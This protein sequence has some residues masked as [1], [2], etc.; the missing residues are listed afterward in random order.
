VGFVADILGF[1]NAAGPHFKLDYSTATGAG[2]TTLTQAQLAS[3]TGVSNILYASADGQSVVLR[4]DVD[5]DTIATDGYP[6]S[7][8]REEASNGTS[9]RAFTDTTGSHKIE[10]LHLPMHLPP[11]NP[12][13]VLLQ[14]HD[15]AQDLI[16]IVVKARSDYATT[17][18]LEVAL[19]LALG[20]SSTSVGI[21]RFIADFGTLAELSSNPKWLQSSITTGLIGPGSTAGWSCTV[22]G[23]T[24]NSWDVGIPTR[25]ASISNTCYY[26]TGMYLQTKW[27]GSGSPGHTGVETDRNE[28]GEAA[29]RFIK[30]THNGESAPVVPVR[31]SRVDDTISNVRWGTKAEGSNTNS[32]S[33][34]LTPAL[35]AS[36]ADGDMI[37]VIARTRR[38]NPSTGVAG[39]PAI[40]SVT[41]S[42]NRLSPGGADYATVA[43][44]VGTDL[45]SHSQRLRIWVRQWFSGM[46]APVLTYT[47]GVPADIMSAQCL[48]ITG[49]KLDADDVMDQFPT[50]FTIGATSTTVIGPSGAL[51][52]NALPGALVLAL[53]ANEFNVPS[54]S[55]NITSGD[56][57]TWAEGGEGI[58]TTIAFQAWANDWAIVPMGAGQSVAAKQTTSTA[59]R[60]TGKS[61]S[62]LCSLKPAKRHRHSNRNCTS[63]G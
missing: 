13:Y 56:S 54:G 37:Y 50:V 49:G 47:S 2:I 52:A 44:T 17:G 4:S 61:A 40:E 46:T 36:L 41:P 59:A 22:N 18:K 9:D 6:R 8:W 29:W 19:K 24:I 48:A 23:V 14:E 28:Y 3:S 7:E 15:S 27:T 62:I 45:T 5:V 16:E 38:T 33:F 35:P 53:L 1:G 25:D 31:G 12:A 63:T 30:V 21:P 20:G 10:T 42:W 60:T 55:V 11:I 58:G 57:L 51:P 39:S 26:K 43:G 34:T 32:V